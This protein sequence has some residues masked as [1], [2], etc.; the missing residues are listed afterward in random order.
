MLMRARVHRT[1]Y[2][3]LCL[4]LIF[5]TLSYAI[6]I[7]LQCYYHISSFSSVKTAQ[8]LFYNWANLLLYCSIIAMTRNRETAIYSATA[9]NASPD[10]REVKTVYVLLAIL[11]FLL[12]TIGPGVYHMHFHNNTK[13]SVTVGVRLGV[14]SFGWFLVISGGVVIGFVIQVWRSSRT[15]GVRDKVPSLHISIVVFNI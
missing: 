8:W 6:S 7:A 9:E 11:L 5:S 15:V 4:A 12:G 14:Y 3:F 1:P 10:D 2:Y 13:Y